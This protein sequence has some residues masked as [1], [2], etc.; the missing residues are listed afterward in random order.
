M[1]EDRLRVIKEKFADD[2]DDDDDDFTT[3][4][5]MLKGESKRELSRFFLWDR[6]LG[7]Y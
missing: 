5:V 7:F 6:F 3:R 1:I 2:D 4:F